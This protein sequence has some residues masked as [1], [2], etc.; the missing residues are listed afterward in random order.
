MN[1][2]ASRGRIALLAACLLAGGCQDQVLS[3]DRLTRSIAGVLGASIADVRLLDRRTDGATDTYVT[4]V[5]RN[6]RAYSCI[7]TGG[8]PPSAGVVDPPTC[9]IIEPLRSPG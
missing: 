1:V 5:V 8:R 6:R 4:A 3:D 2:S 9:Y 7:V